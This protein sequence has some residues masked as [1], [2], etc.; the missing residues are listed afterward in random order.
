MGMS[1]YQSRFSQRSR[2]IRKYIC[3]NQSFVIGTGFYAMVGAGKTVSVKLSFL[4]LEFQV[5]GAGHWEEKMD[6]KW[7]SERT[8][9]THEQEL[10]FRRR[11]QNLCFMSDV[12]GMGVLQKLGAF[13]TQLL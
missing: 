9:L 4:L 3:D 12:E 2:T 5:H 1:L 7:G 11:D 13:I 10:E 6:G 8:S